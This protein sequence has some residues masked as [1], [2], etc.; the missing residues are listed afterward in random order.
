MQFP[1]V[2]KTFLAQISA[3]VIVS[4]AK[5]MRN[6]KDYLV[7]QKADVDLRFNGPVY[8]YFA[9]IAKD[10]EDFTKLFNQVINENMGQLLADLKSYD[11]KI[12]GNFILQTMSGTFDTFSLQELF[13]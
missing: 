9:N 13:I 1:S 2:N 11:E 3:K 6:G 10:K 5:I 8:L 12:L 4:G 7:P